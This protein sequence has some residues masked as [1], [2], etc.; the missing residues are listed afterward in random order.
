MN[1]L[2][3]VGTVIGTVSADAIRAVGA[4][5]YHNPV[6]QDLPSFPSDHT[7]Q[8]EEKAVTTR[9]ALKPGVEYC[10]AEGVIVQGLEQYPGT[11]QGKRLE[12]EEANL[13]GRIEKQNERQEENKKKRITLKHL[14]TC[15]EE[16]IN[17]LEGQYGI[18]WLTKELDFS[19]FKAI[20][21]TLQGK[22]DISEDLT[23]ASEI[24]F[25]HRNTSLNIKWFSVC[26]GHILKPEKAEGQLDNGDINDDMAYRTGGANWAERAGKITA[27]FLTLLRNTIDSKQG[28]PLNKADIIEALTQ[29]PQQITDRYKNKEG[30]YPGGSTATF[31]YIIN[32]E[33]LLICNVGDSQALLACK[34]EDSTIEMQQLSLNDTVEERKEEILANKGVIDGEVVASAVG[35]LTFGRSIGDLGSPLSSKGSVTSYKISELAKGKKELLLLIMSDGITHL[36]NN[37]NIAAFMLREGITMEQR[38]KDL[39]ETC[40]HADEKDD[41]SLI[42]I[43]LMKKQ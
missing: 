33:Y 12:A 17:P 36:T 31:A 41:I 40:Y 5:L 21:S 6:A 28:E 10:P 4:V 34:N 7:S 37:N 19:P 42:A 11:D 38:V 43:D 20:G 2:F 18:K 13:K 30:F 15:K 3:R 9:R 8:V 29:A 16:E 32:N 35:D 39:I 22:K 24:T 14:A 23:G 26:D 25:S 1:V 27:N